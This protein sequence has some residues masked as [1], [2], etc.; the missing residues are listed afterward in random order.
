[1]GISFPAGVLYFKMP[2]KQWRKKAL[3][4]TLKTLE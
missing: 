2:A 3:P 1:M 4:I